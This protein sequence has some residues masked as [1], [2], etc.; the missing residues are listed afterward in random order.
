M[1]KDQ[2]STVQGAVVVVAAAVVFVVDVQ[3]MG[4]DALLALHVLQRVECTGKCCRLLSVHAALGLLLRERP[5]R[6]ACSGRLRAVL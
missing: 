4:A 2:D 5:L 3:R 1:A 6:P